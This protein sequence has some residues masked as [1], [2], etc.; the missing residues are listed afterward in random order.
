MERS[1]GIRRLLTLAPV[2]RGVQRAVGAEKF[3]RR[4]SKEIIACTPTASVVDIGCGTADIEAHLGTAAYV[5]FDPNEHYVSSARRRIGRDG[6]VL[7]AAIGDD[8]LPARLPGDVDLVIAVGVFHHLD[9]HLVAAALGLASSILRDGGRF[10]A[11]DPGFV[12]GQH[13][14]ARALISRDRGQNVR[15]VESTTE[16]VAPHFPDHTIEVRTDLLH[17]PY[18][19]I[20]V[21][22]VR[23][24]S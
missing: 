6:A 11:V 22:G 17:V 14:L 1:D 23:A 15:T 5:G 2:Y 20:I 9:D 21:D 7:H 12:E 8:D 13:R 19:H 3:M 16:L 4:V 24:G 18:T 10:V